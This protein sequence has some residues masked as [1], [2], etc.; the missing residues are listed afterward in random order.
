MTTE[1][2][3]KALLR[4]GNSLCRETAI[5]IQLEES[6]IEEEQKRCGAFMKAVFAGDHKRA[7]LLADGYNRLAFLRYLLSRKRMDEYREL[8][9]SVNQ[10]I[11]LN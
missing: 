2:M 3:I 9:L 10:L 4:S 5:R 8:V 6:T 11:T 1:E 7:F